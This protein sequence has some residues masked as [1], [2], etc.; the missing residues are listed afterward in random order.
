MTAISAVF[1]AYKHIPTRK[2]FQI[3]L[4]IPEE[5]TAEVFSILGIPSSSSDIWVG[6]ARLEKE[7]DS[8][9]QV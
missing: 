8:T 2:T 9:Q 5:K 6:V 4:E 3:I 1:H 7:P